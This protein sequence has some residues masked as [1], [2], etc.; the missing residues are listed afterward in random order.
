MWLEHLSLNRT[1]QLVL[2]FFVFAWVALIVILA[3]APEVY[4][5]LL[6]L[7]GSERKVP[8]LAFL[9]ALSTFLGLLGIEV[10]RH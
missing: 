5:Q 7:P 2:G 6:R 8:T 10:V 1:Q 4:E 9:M 3:T